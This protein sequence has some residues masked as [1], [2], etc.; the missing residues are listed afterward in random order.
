M[1]KRYWTQQEYVSVA[2]ELVRTGVLNPKPEDAYRV[3]H[4]ILTIPG[5]TL[6][7][8]EPNRM[9]R[10]R[11]IV[12]DIRDMKI[13]PADVQRAVVRVKAAKKTGTETAIVHKPLRESNPSPA[14]LTHAPIK[15]NV[16]VVHEPVMEAPRSRLREVLVKT[17][18]DSIPF[19]L[20]VKSVVEATVKTCMDQMSHQIA[21]MLDQTTSN[22]RVE[23]HHE[24]HKLEQRLC[25]A[26]DIELPAEAEPV[27]QEIIQVSE[28][29]KPKKHNPEMRTEAPRKPRILVAG[30]LASHR[31]ALLNMMK[32]TNLGSKI[33]IEFMLSTDQANKVNKHF[34]LAIVMRE[35]LPPAF[36]DLIRKRSD[37]VHITPTTGL[38][39]LLHTFRNSTTEYLE[40][41]A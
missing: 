15:Q 39:S 38:T 9:R 35:V 22:V 11:S 18:N 25:K 31:D 21:A 6:E 8:F 23:V 32:T 33:D 40:R 26:W 19:D 14:S 24:M 29:I 1:T 16:V 10:I 5:I 13:N 3:A 12:K 36:V 34:S 7:T 2:N 4:K 28:M 20:L 27:T 41:H 17:S 30:V 37:D